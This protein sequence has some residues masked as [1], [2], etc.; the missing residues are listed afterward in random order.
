MVNFFSWTIQTW[1]GLMMYYVKTKCLLWQNITIKI[2]VHIGYFI[3]Y[4]I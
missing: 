3:K 4:N 1:H 2:Y